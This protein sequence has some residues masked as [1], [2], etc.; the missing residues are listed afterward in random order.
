M[1]ISE[2]GSVATAHPYT[3]GH[4]GA[5]RPFTGALAFINKSGRT[6]NVT[7]VAAH[8]GTAPTGASIV[9]DV[10]VG[11]V[12][13]WTT[14]GNR[15]AVAIAATDASTDTIEAGSWPDGSTVTIDVVQVGSTIAGSDLTVAVYAS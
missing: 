14:V 8:V 2:G 13:I 1:P 5:A 11:G 6:L 4:R 3:S 15:L 10:L 7:R 12:T 9:L